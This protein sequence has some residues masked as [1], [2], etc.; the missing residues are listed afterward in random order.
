MRRRNAVLIPILFAL[1]VVGRG[2]SVH[3]QAQ[4][5]VYTKF[6]TE[7]IEQILKGLNLDYKKSAS[8]TEGIFYYDYKRDKYSVRL[9]YFNGRDL[10]LDVLLKDQPLETLNRWNGKARFSRASLH[11]SDDKGAF[12]ALEWNLDLLG[13]V[14]ENNVRHFIK[15]FHEE[16]GE[17]EKFVG[18]SEAV[19]PLAPGGDKVFTG[20]S[21]DKLESILKDMKVVYKKS[22]SKDMVTT[23][24]DYE[25]R[26]LKLRIYNFG[27]KDLMVDAIF[28]KIPLEQVN[29]YNFDRKFIRTVLYS[30]P[31]ANEYTALESNLD[32]TAGTSEN[33]I[34]RFILGFEEEAVRFLAFVNNN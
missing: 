1:A 7:Q 27:G 2:G 32:C 16:I 15:T 21:N 25:S 11:R 17:F 29:K 18:S 6:T 33:I 4:D 5:K 24:Y 22:Q 12:T 28:K 20:I 23:L 19:P 31:N 8:K 26:N 30:P 9:H 14:T 10:M 13:G 3:A 34:R